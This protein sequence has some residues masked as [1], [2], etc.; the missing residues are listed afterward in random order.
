M[1]GS[2]IRI[3]VLANA[4]NAISGIQSTTK[5]LGVL[6]RVGSKLGSALKV[7]I[8]GGAVAATAG[9]AVFAKDSIQGAQESLQIH[10]VFESQLHRL[11]AAG[12]LAFKDSVQF[13]GDFG[14]AIGQDDDRVLAVVNK[15]S[16]FP[17]AFRKGA[18]GAQAMERATKAAFDL[19]ATGIGSAESNIIGIGKALDNPIKGM[20]ALS[21]AGVSFSEAETAS[22]KAAVAR[23]DIAKAQQILLKGIESNAKGAAEAGVSGMDKLK[24]RL[25]NIGEGFA[26]E[27]L[28]KINAFADVLSSKLPGAA[29]F[30]EAAFRKIGPVIGTVVAAFAANLPGVIAGV[31]DAFAAL[32]PA[33]SAIVSVLTA[34]LPGAIEVVKTGFA[35]LVALAGNTAFQAFAVGIAAIVASLKLYAL[36]QGVVATVTGVWTAAQAALNVV[37]A[38]NPIGLIVLAII[39]LTAG[40]IFA[41][42][43]SETFRDIVT[44]SFD[45]VKGAVVAT[46]DAIKAASSATWDAVKAAVMVEDVARTVHLAREAGPLIPIPQDSIDR[47]FDRYQNVYGQ[48]EDERR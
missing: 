8:L 31:R 11:G 27:L 2:A 10:K 15:L 9:L 32:Q 23:G 30:V 17:N 48:G 24:A 4:A 44:G 28:P 13:A 36:Y 34:S 7:G 45:A 6:G 39:G 29:A 18:L 22:I 1:A 37:L 3:A 47:L 46:W 25:A 16:T 5:E 41:W 33:L 20:T 43:Q 38:A 14:D 26:G 21:K 12:K 35:V 40:L 42:K 19:E